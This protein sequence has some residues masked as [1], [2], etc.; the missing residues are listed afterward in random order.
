VVYVGAEM[1]QITIEQMMDAADRELRRLNLS[2]RTVYGHC[3][4][5][6]EFA[7]YCAQNAMQIYSPDTGLIYFLQRYGLDMADSTVKLTEQQRATRR[8]IRFLDDIYQFGCARRNSHHDYK[9]PPAY[10]DV[11]ES[12]LSDCIK[13]NGAPGTIDV[14][15][16]KLKQFLCYLDGR[17]ILLPD[18]TASDVSDYMTTLYQYKRET[19]HI[20]S[21]VLRD[22]F[23][24]LHTSGILENNLAGDVPRPK[25]YVEESFPETWTPEE[26]RQLLSAINRRTA[27]G[28]RDYA[29]ILLAVLLGMRAGDI[30]ALNFKEIDWRKKVIT[31]TQQKS[32]KINTL[33]LLPLI[34]EAIIDYLKNGRL[35]SDC[36][37]VF[38]R[39]IHPYG[40]IASSSTLSE[41]IKR[42]MRQA[43]LTIKS[44]KVAHSMRHTV[45]STL[46]RN[47]VPLMTVSNIMG[48][49]TPKTTIAYTKV[50][51]PAL[52]K[53]ALS[54]GARRE[55][56]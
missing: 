25:I 50:D 41:T 48:H 29:M 27:I 8:T 44:R 17:R 55:L 45:A 23:R 38:I 11:L 39:H 43:G 49:D 22:F 14:K 24:Y 30:C 1:V 47:G 40:A 37:N 53:C 10:A 28:T 13:N 9:V 52:R 21:S 6:R 42:Y 36:D 18:I 46:L 56:P 54:Y 16:T 2:P 51:I 4:E 31:Y 12:Y 35:D 26:I 19:I 15:R 7:D 34:G 33:P 3:K 20:I 5:L 32:G